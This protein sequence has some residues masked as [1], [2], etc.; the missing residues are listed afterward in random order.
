MKK[1]MYCLALIVTYGLFVFNHRQ[2]VASGW[3]DRNRIIRKT[4]YVFKTYLKADDIIIQ[5]M[6]QL[7]TLTGTVSEEIPQIIGKRNCCEACPE[8]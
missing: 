4:V 2:S 5:S 6:M 7:S 1:T 8:L 3:M